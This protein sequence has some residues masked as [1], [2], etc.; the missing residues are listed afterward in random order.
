MAEDIDIFKISNVPN[1]TPNV[2]FLFDYSNSMNLA[3]PNSAT[4]RIDALRQV[5]QE[6]LTSDQYAFNAGLLMFDYY[7]RGSGPDF[8]IVDKNALAN[9]VD[10]NIPPSY[11]VG[12]ALV[13]MIL[14]GTPSAQNTQLVSSYYE[15]ARYW[16]GNLTDHGTSTYVPT[17]YNLAG[18]T[19]PYNGYYSG[20]TYAAHPGTYGLSSDQYTKVLVTRPARVVMV[21]R[22]RRLA[23][24]VIL[25]MP[26]WS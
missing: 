23:Q 10:I 22:V 12:D 15:A 6:L 5:F 3:L 11:T 17:W 25:S 9:T 21:R 18:N 1:T 16:M 2:M 13:S 7:Y 24:P 8:P 20:S 4:T 26:I 19:E 14:N